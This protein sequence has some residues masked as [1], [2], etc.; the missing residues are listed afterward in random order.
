M[1]PEEFKRGQN[2]IQNNLNG[3][4]NEFRKIEKLNLGKHLTDFI[5]PYK[6]QPVS[7]ML[8]PRQLFFF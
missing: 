2:G 8:L 3:K 6:Q 7:T 5:G 1:S 4:E